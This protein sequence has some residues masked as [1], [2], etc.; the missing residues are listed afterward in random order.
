MHLYHH[1][2]LIHSPAPLPLTS[3]LLPHPN[4]LPSWYIQTIYSP[5][6][7]RCL[8]LPPLPSPCRPHCLLPGALS[9][10]TTHRHVLVHTFK[11]RF[12]MW[13]KTYLSSPVC[14]ISHN[15]LWLIHI[16]V[17]VTGSLFFA[18]EQNSVYVYHIFFSLS[19]VD[20]YVGGSVSRLLWNK[21]A[22]NLQVQ[23]S[24]GAG[25]ESPCYRSG[26]PGWCSSSDLELTLH[27]VPLKVSLP[28]S[29]PAQVTWCF[30]T[31]G[32][33]ERW[34]GSQGTFS[35]GFLVFKEDLK[36]CRVCVDHVDF[37][38]WEL[39]FGSVAPL[40]IGLLGVLVFRILYRF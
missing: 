39:S 10:A 27:P 31:N 6:T 35:F 2:V 23:V 28:E 22:M 36:M 32:P 1:T 11:S 16:L 7:V 38:L 12:L 40:S 14:L 18:A 13:E 25:S 4:G 3:P 15:D 8:F 37:F 26:L 5:H 34:D 33:S 9:T 29:S 30:H 19:F 20:G 17:S 24:L 21:V